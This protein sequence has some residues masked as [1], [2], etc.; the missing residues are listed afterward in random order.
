MVKK[1]VI[2][3]EKST[4]NYVKDDSH[5]YHCKYGFIKKEDM[6]KNGVVVTNKDVNLH[7]I[8]ADVS[9]CI[10]K[11]KRSP[12][13]IPK[14]DVG[15]IL[16]QCGVN[17]K[18][19]CVEAGSGS[20]AAGIYLAMH[21]KKVHSFDIRD[22]HLKI[23]IKNCEDLGLKNIVH[24][25]HDIYEGI[26]VK[27]VDLLLLD[28]PAP[29][30]VIEHAKVAI[31]QGGHIVSYSPTIMQTAD[32]VNALDDNFFHVRTVELIQR[33]WEVFGRKVRPKTFQEMGHSGFMTF[34]RRL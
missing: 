30:R 5:D 32:F 26:P 15:L 18:M 23:A 2:N 16:T 20:G 17:K 19:V 14:K 8:D 9:D 7:V 34:V 29:W 33:D 31:K 4:I 10:E 28:V 25:N 27:N 21:S 1:V 13:I 22:D 24:K 6:D 11:I 12:Q 3:K